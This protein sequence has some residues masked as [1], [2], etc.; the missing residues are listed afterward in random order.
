MRLSI[1]L[2]LLKHLL[3]I[4]SFLSKL[5]VGP[6]KLSNDVIYIYN[7]Y[8]HLYKQDRSLNYGD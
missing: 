5:Y 1:K 7:K 8:F 4:S 2:L 3:I 6:N